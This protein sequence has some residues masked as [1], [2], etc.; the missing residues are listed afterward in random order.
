MRWTHWTQTLAGVVAMADEPEVSVDVDAIPD[1]LKAR[2]Q[3]LF[4][5]ASAD[6][7]R[8]PLATP[9]A[10]RG[11]S[12]T[13]PDE[14]LSFDEAVEAAQG[15]PSAGIGFVFAN[16]NDD[17]L[18]GLYGA[19]DLDGC[20]EDGPNGRR[21]KDWLPELTPF[22]GNTYMEYS[23]S[24]EGIHIPLVGFEPPEWWANAHFTADEHEGVEAYGSKF[25]TFTG[26]KLEP[27][28]DGIGDVDLGAVREWLAD[29]YE[30][31]EGEDPRESN[32]TQPATDPRET[33]KSKDE[34][35]D[36]TTTND[37]DDILDAVD[38]LDA[39]D[40]PLSSSYMHDENREWESWDPAYR[41]SAS[42]Q[43]LKRN[44]NS[45]IFLD[46][47]EA[48][49]G[50]CTP[51]GPLDLFAAEEGIIRKPYDRLQGDDW[52]DAVS[53]ARD[54]GAPIPEF[55]GV[56]GDVPEDA[57]IDTTEDEATTDRMIWDAWSSARENQSLDG[58]SVVPTPALRHIV[59]EQT[60]YNLDAI[61]TDD[62]AD[63]P[64]RPHNLALNW[65][66][67]DWGREA[68]GIDLRD[69]DEE[70]EVTGR[71]Y[72]Q[73]DPASTFTWAG[74]REIY[75]NSKEDGRY[76]AVRL[77]RQEYEFLTPEDDEELHVYNEDL[78]IYEHGAIYDIGRTLDRE[79][80]SHY[81][82][83]EKN[84]I[85]SR[86]KERTVEREELE[87]GRFE[88]TYICVANG[89]LDIDNRELKDHDPKWLFTRDV[90]VRHD[91]DADCPEIRDFLRD[92]T[93]RDEDWKTMVEMLGNS[94]LPHYNY[95]SFLVL[96]GRGAN[97]KSTWF[98]VVRDFLGHHNIEN[99]PLQ[100][101]TDNRF[102]PAQLVGQWAN[103]GGDL[104][105]NKIRDMGT[106]KD[107]TGGGEVWA[108]KKGEDGFNFQNRAKMMFAANQPP[109]LGERSHAIAR[110]ILPI[111]LPHR[112]TPDE[113][114]EHKD[115]DEGIL[116]RMTTEEE[117]SG[118]LNMALDAIERLRTKGDFSLPES[119]EERLEYYEQFSD[120]IKMFAVNCLE[121][122]SGS[123]EQKSDV[124]NAYTSF[125]EEKGREPVIRQTFWKQLGK[126]TLDI[127]IGRPQKPDGSRPRVVENLTF[128]DHGK[129]FAPHY[130]TPE[131]EVP[132]ISSV[133]PGDDGVTVEGRVQDIDTDQPDVIAEKA[134][135]VDTTDSITVTIWA[136]SNTPA[137]EDGQAYRFK[138]VEVTEYE[139][140]REIQVSENSGVEELSPGVGN[141]P[142]D[143]PGNNRQLD[144]AAD[145]G[146][147]ADDGTASGPS[148]DTA[149]ESTSER[150]DLESLPPQIVMYVRE[151][152]ERFPDGVPQ[153]M[154][155]GNFASEGYN[156]AHVE[157]SIDIA[158]EK[159]GISEPETGMLRSK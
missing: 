127:S 157:D 37:Y 9:T 42:G 121:N 111:R 36:I 31:I 76:A 99:I 11:A 66:R 148:A 4:W 134:T 20:V 6:K 61:E 17:Y 81:S 115:R 60:D 46:F 145:G 135:L 106:L 49:P 146:T 41:Q 122:D 54:R 70:R 22:I 155:V 71:Y 16:T 8:K 57:E 114:D 3:W 95:E 74:V 110:R 102:A 44:K 14:W 73:K 88:G 83:H 126:T 40:L 147:E 43:S 103:I 119:P 12:W 13:D 23:P 136:D 25:F 72:K 65:V 53:R 15:V 133:A 1:E 109:V 129:Q 107:L 156:A 85:V 98:N 56:D 19:L 38:H 152:E 30:V 86:L 159:G 79:L 128:T 124:Y 39:R 34:V 7:P 47:A 68:L 144:A 87:A 33:K 80:H 10:N 131:Y 153:E 120:H 67:Y 113:D 51:F 77:L 108:E 32:A 139:S 96:F 55:A 140:G 125:C 150:K 18:R 5:N 117:L 69:D 2:D 149:T 58:D 52:H 132:T 130:D 29:V 151:Q 92:I 100:D 93:R 97:G 63:L 112:Y 84:E 154:V 21:P 91:P 104:P 62:D 137:L 89:V 28:A 142:A 50:Q 64:W 123:E 158:K 105:Q 82:T 143:D 48:N 90:P 118:L 141:V 24:G 45:G 35:A 116:D 94:L 138:N 101:L 78:G 26:D 59:R 27:A 75:E